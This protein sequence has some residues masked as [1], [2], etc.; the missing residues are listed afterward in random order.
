[1][2]QLEKKHLK[3]LYQILLNHMLEYKKEN[4]DYYRYGICLYTIN[5]K[6]TEEISYSEWN[7][8]YQHFNEQR[9]KYYGIFNFLF[10]LSKGIRNNCYA[11]WWEQSPEG[12]ELRTRFI[13]LL[14]NKL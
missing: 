11:Y 10:P 1:M 6:N 9:P 2:T 4:V 7:L 14:I 13:K 8:L 3:E 5:L 12:F